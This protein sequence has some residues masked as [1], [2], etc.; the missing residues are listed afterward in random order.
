ML[1]SVGQQI[2]EELLEFL[3]RLG[4]EI[5]KPIYKN[6]SRTI[7]FKEIYDLAQLFFHN[8]ENKEESIRRIGI[9]LQLGG[10]LNNCDG[11]GSSYSELLK[12]HYSESFIARMGLGEIFSKL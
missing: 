1:F 5:N 11:K 10:D 9:I 7:L 8:K 3:V 6:K 4:A 12:S 2:D